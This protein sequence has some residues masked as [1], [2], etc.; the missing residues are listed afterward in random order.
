MLNSS[1]R[2][3]QMMRTR[4]WWL[5]VLKVVLLVAVAVTVVGAVVMLLWNWLMPAL[6][7]WQTIDFWQAIGLLVLSRI[8]LGGLRGGWGQRRHWRGRMMERWE[9]M[10]D[11]QRQQFRD[12]FGSS[13]RRHHRRGGPPDEQMV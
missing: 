11:E 13:M 1:N 3:E 4:R 5:H 9:Q 12:Q 6:F 2:K 7:G 8:L 10:S